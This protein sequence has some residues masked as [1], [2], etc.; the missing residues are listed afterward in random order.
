MEICP[1][2]AALIDADIRT[3]GLTGRVRGH[4]GGNVSFLRLCEHT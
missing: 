4:D 2:G 3:D 1:I